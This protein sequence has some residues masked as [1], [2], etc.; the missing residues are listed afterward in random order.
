MK[1][2]ISS[3]IPTSIR[4]ILEKYEPDHDQQYNHIAITTFKTRI[5]AIGTNVYAKSHPLQQKFAIQAGMV[6]KRYLHAEIASLVKSR[7][8]IDTMYVFRVDKGGELRISRP[9]PICSLA[10]KEAGIDCYHS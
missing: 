3:G 4:K 9:C 5:V 8:K 2:I 1:Q 6:H 10:I 7:G